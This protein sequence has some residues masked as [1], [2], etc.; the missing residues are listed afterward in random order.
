M[1]TILY[2][3]DC[4]KNSVAAL[5]FANFLSEKF[6]STL[7]V[8]HVFDVPISLASPV[9]VSYM[10]KE[11]RLFVEHRAKLKAFCAEHLGE[12][13]LQGTNISFVVDEDGSVVDGILENAIRFSVDL[14]VVGTKGQS[15]VKEFL[16]GS[17]TKS[18][19]KTVS[20]PIIAVPEVYRVGKLKTFTY[21]TD[22][23]QADIFAIRKLVKI[24][25]VFD[26]KIRI[27]HITTKKEYAGDQQMEWFKE[28]LQQKVVYEK[29][30]YDIIFSDTILK[31]LQW[32]LQETNVDVLV[33]LERSKDNILERYLQ[34]DLVQKMVKEI[35]VPL[36][37]YKEENQ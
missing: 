37:C 17:T 16:L 36:L 19:I 27:L 5:K 3:T 28:M 15:P 34:Q 18:L 32:Y 30:D 9:S 8:M 7:V 31:E 23:E 2:A 11:K 35:N 25:Q 14:I 10:K 12:S 21:A 20:C 22:F 26:A 24:A 33:M 6:D 29:I 1:K 4:S 13:S